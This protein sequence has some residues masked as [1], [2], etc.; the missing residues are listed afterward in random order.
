MMDRQYTEADLR[1]A[2]ANYW[3]CVPVHKLN[4]EDFMAEL[5]K[6]KQSFRKTEVVAVGN[7]LGPYGYQHY[8]DTNP[9]LQEI[10]SLNYNELPQYVHDLRDGVVAFL[11]D[12]IPYT[13]LNYIRIDFDAASGREG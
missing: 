7:A 9:V 12:E 11:N 8:Q 6:S 3:P 10:R 5:T 4:F 13:E 2:W 1:K